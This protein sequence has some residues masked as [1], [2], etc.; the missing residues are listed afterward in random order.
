MKAI[1][2]RD[3]RVPATVADTFEYGSYPTGSREQS[4]WSAIE[5]S[6]TRSATS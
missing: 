6:T 3:I 4:H 2:T 1:A 5:W